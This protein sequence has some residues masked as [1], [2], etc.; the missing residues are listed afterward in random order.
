MHISYIEK[1]IYLVFIL[2]FILIF[3][4]ILI[5]TPIVEYIIIPTLVN[6][7]YLYIV[8]EAFKNS[9]VF[10]KAEF[11]KH[12]KNIKP[13]YE[14]KSFKGDLSQEQ[15]EEYFKMLDEYL[16]KNKPFT[17]PEITIERLAKMTKIPKYKISKVINTKENKNFFD[18][19]NFYRIEEAKKMLKSEKMN[20]LSIDGVGYEVGFNSKSAF[21]RAFKK[22]THQTPKEF[23]KSSSN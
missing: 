8:Y 20:F 19:I 16:R 10:S 2:N 17:N 7:F 3:C 14:G 13:V 5:P 4:Y 22:F 15:I 18:F 9:V 1:F 21:Y 23:F 11:E 6:I 12:L